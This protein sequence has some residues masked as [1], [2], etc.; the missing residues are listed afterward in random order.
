MAWW[1]SSC[2]TC[3]CWA[4]RSALA[5]WK[6]GNHSELTREVY[7]WRWSTHLWPALCMRFL[8]P[9]QE[10]GWSPRTDPPRTVHHRGWLPTR[11][12]SGYPFT[13][14]L[15]VVGNHPQR[16]YIHTRF[17]TLRVSLWMIRTI[18]KAV[19]RFQSFSRM[20]GSGSMIVA[21]ISFHDFFTAV[22]SLLSWLL[23]LV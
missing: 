3:C 6:C 22:W 18:L 21:G 14:I 16:I 17:T 23:I 15:N 2:W 8:E 11:F 4:L 12:T 20:W 13:T 5:G 1:V 10:H 9:Y 19:H 7:G